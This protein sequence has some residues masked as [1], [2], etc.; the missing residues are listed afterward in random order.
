MSYT[1]YDMIA[2]NNGG[3][4]ARRTVVIKYGGAAL[5]AS[6][7][8]SCF[9]EDLMSLRRAGTHVVVVHGGGHEV[10]A[11]AARLEVEAEFVKGQRRTDSQMMDAVTMALAGTVN[12]QLVRSINASGGRAVGLS[13]V[14]G[15]LLVARR[16]TEPDL[17]LVGRVEQVNVQ[18]LDLLL[19][20]GYTP[21]IATLGSGAEGAVY[22]INADLAAGAVAAALGADLLVY[23][24][25]V[26]GVRNGGE[27]IPLMTAEE[28][29]ELIA[30]GVIH[31]GMIPKVESALE[32]VDG[33]V[34]SVRI[35]D[36]RRPG[37]L[38]QLLDG[39]AVGTA[40]IRTG[41]DDDAGVCIA[42][43]GMYEES[44]LIEGVIA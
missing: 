23:M 21:V 33:G 24:S 44:I 35:I 36:G 8:D 42:A 2:G 34:A 11:L 13:G 1:G 31:G 14:D 20:G 15:D 10:T 41:P 30:C 28:A 26:E 29:R 38:R 4:C 18:L 9:A 27:I 3:L 6:A 22:N 5:A 19:R 16:L 39:E 17:G 7:P 12:T 40:I 32:A 25:D 37:A 43:P